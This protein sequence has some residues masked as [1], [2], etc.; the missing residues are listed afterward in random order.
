MISLNLS[1]LPSLVSFPK[2]F[3]ASTL[4][5]AFASELGNM[6]LLRLHQL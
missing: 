6:I 3:C 2:E 4:R 5:A 1:P